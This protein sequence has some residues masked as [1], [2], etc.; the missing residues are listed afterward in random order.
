MGNVYNHRV[1]KNKKAALHI[2]ERPVFY[3]F[4]A[5]QNTH[6]QPNLR[7]SS[8]RRLRSLIGIVSDTVSCFSSRFA[9]LALSRSYCVCMFIH[10]S[11]GISRAFSK[12]TATLSDTLRLPLMVSLSTEVLM[13][14]ILSYS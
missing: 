14:L 4:K 13:V 6:A 10:T 2:E 7:T 3:C 1:H 11:A 5:N 8:L 9:M 12:A